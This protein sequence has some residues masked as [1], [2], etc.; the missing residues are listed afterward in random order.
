MRE[1]TKNRRFAKALILT[2]LFILIFAMSM[3]VNEGTL[4]PLIDAT[5]GTFI[6]KQFYSNEVT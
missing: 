2:G 1:K 3:S 5:L 4:I 6:V